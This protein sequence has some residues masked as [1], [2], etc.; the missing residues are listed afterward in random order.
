MK[1]I[2]SHNHIIA[3]SEITKCNLSC[4]DN[5]RH[6]LQDG[7]NTLTYGHYNTKET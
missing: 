1:S 3:S 4:F 5:K 7:I 2:K 6:I